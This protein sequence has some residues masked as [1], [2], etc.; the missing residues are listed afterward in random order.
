MGILNS[1]R[2][3]LGAIRAWFLSRW[4][5][6]LTLGTKA[7]TAHPFRV[8]DTYK[9]IS[10]KKYSH[11]PEFEPFFAQHLYQCHLWS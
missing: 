4:K 5:P 7:S 8:G 2:V 6:S 3:M 11:N 1:G 9:K 10:C